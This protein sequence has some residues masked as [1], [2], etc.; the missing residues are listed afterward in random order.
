VNRTIR[1]LFGAVLCALT[2]I[3]GCGDSTPKTAVVFVAPVNSHEQPVKGLPVTKT[4][5]GPCG[6]GSDSVGGHVYRCPDAGDPCWAVN[7]NVI[8]TDTVLCMEAPWS[9]SVVK[10]ITTGLV[11]NVF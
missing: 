9:T 6:S 2:V 4:V 11:G 5:F 8:P 10:D 3:A 7:S 1:S